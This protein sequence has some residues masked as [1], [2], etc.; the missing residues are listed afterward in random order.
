MYETSQ[1]SRNIRDEIAKQLNILV[2]GVS[3]AANQDTE[4]IR[5]LFS[6]NAEM[7]EKTSVKPYGLSSA[8]LPGVRSLV[9]RIGEHKNSRVVIGHVDQDRPETSAGN[10]VLY[11]AY[12][13]K[14]RLDALEIRLGSEDADEP[15]VLGNVLLDFLDQLIT[16]IQSLTVICSAP[17]NSSSPPIN[18]AQFE[19]LR[20]QFITLQT[21]ISSSVFTQKLITPDV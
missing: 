5:S 7:T 19:A 8:P 17:G 12:G 11:N 20:A 14:F 15:L 1:L 13:A 4:N 2:Y 16:A 3:G 6:A 9:A 18:V 10:T 21:L